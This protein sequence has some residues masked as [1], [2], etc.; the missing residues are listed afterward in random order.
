MWLDSTGVGDPIYDDLRRAGIKIRGYKFTGES[1]RVL[2]ENLSI[3]WDEGR[4]TIPEEASPL[5]NELKAFTY[6]ISRTGNVRY[7]APEG[8]HDDCV[9][10]LALAAWGQRTR[11]RI[12]GYTVYRKRE[13]VR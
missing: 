1:K 2:I 12:E 8:L 5:I 9:I 6:E 10:S 11:G 13:I 3:T 4:Y 7:S